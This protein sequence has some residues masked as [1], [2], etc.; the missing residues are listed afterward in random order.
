MSMHPIQQ[1]IAR[2]KSGGHSGIYSCCSAN[3]YVLRAVM[4]RAKRHNLPALIEATAN[5]VNQ[6]GGYTGQTPETFAAWCLELAEQ[7]GFDASGLILGGDH[8]G[9]LTWT[10]L[11][12]DEAMQNAGK[13]INDYVSTS[14]TKIHIDTSMRLASDD[15]LKPLSD[16]IISERGA[17]LCAI[18]E[19]AFANRKNAFPDAASPVYVI[20]SEVPIPGGAQETEEHAVTSAENCRAT[21]DA[22]KEAFGKYGLDEAW[23]RVT[24]VVVQPGV[25]FGEDDVRVYNREKARELCE[26]IR[27]NPGLV[28]EGHSTDYQ[29][30]Q[31]LREMMEDGII[32][33]KVGPALTFALR[34][35][36]FAL[37]NIEKIMLRGRDAVFSGFADALE[38]AMLQNPGNWNK[39]YH[40]D[41]FKQRVNRAYGFSDRARYYLPEPTVAQAV[42]RLTENLEK[43]LPLPLLSQFMPIQ[44]QRVRDGLLKNCVHELIM[45]RIGDCA[46][47]YI[48]AMGC[49]AD[50]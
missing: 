16:K 28:F 49:N 8:L 50:R 43:P 27:E 33:Q 24:A 13:L 30:R 34:E 4:R 14:F 46:D 36:L 6:F 35:A 2:H 20:G 29:P 48:F 17:R 21:I 47:D 37:E 11:H 39:H 26:T 42:E 32:I 38:T 45:D 23:N 10:N 9:P 22:F 5:Q 7:E 19:E 18:A 40:G 3:E 1:I 12:E 31:A 44:Y 25:E 15:K 41:G